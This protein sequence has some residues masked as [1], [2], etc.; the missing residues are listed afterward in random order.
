MRY[1]NRLQDAV[2]NN[3]SSERVWAED[4]MRYNSSHESYVGKRFMLARAAEIFH[5]CYLRRNCN[6]YEIIG[7]VPAKLYLDCDLKCPEGNEFTDKDAAYVAK[8]VFYFV[9]Q[10]LRLSFER[11]QTAPMIFNASTNRKLSFHYV[12]PRYVFAN[13]QCHMAAYVFELEQYVMKQIG[14]LMTE[15][16]S[17]R[18]L[19]LLRMVHSNG[20]IDMAVYKASQQFRLLGNRKMLKTNTLVKVSDTITLVDPNTTFNDVVHNVNVCI[21]IK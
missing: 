11:T 5:H 3:L 7:Y 10:H 16:L 20:F 9:A 19:E 12:N 15:S 8:V 1:F 2:T 6:I 4:Y 13:A 17:E 18:Q 14:L 21:F